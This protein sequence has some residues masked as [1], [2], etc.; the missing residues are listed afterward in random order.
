MDDLIKIEECI[1]TKY[2][3]DIQK[4]EKNKQ[5]TQGNVFIVYTKNEKYVIKR[6]TNLKHTK[7]MIS[8]HNKLIN[9]GL[10]VPKIIKNK[11]KEDY[12][13]INTNEYIVVYS[14]IY[15]KQ[16]SQLEQ[17]LDNAQITEMAK[18]LYKLHSSTYGKNL[19]Y[20][21]ELPFDIKYSTQRKSA[22]HFDLTKDNIF[23]ENNHIK[24]IDFDDAKYGPAVCDV[25]I[26][27][28]LC[29]VSKKTGINEEAI[30]TF[31]KE[32]YA[33]EPE[34]KDE[35]KYIKE[36]AIKWIEYT[37]IENQFD[38]STTESFETKRKLL[39]NDKI[40]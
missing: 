31:I 27:I 37:L 8:L 5:S 35:I 18:E 1:K 39:M 16:I 11:N 4:I 32:Y 23:I 40:E 7:S 34:A 22:L 10:V 6:Y 26:I 36:I 25:A 33:N 3:I 14:F 29:F 28:A 30:K 24:F 21:P 19:C 38:L 20:L 13:I 9:C 17:K 2:E 12:C 15:G